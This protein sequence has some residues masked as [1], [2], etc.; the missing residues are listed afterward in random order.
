MRHASRVAHA[1]LGAIV[2]VGL[3]AAIWARSGTALALEPRFKAGQA[4]LDVV[5][6]SGASQ[7]YDLTLSGGYWA[8]E[9]EG[10]QP[11]MSLTWATPDGAF[12]GGAVLFLS[13]PAETGTFN[14]SPTDALFIS[15]GVPGKPTTYSNGTADPEGGGC[16]VTLAGTG[17]NGS[18]LEG[19][20]GSF[21][22]TR[23]GFRDTQ[24]GQIDATGTFSA[25][26]AGPTA[27]ATAT[28]AS[29]AAFGVGLGCGVREDAALRLLACT[30]SPFG[31]AAD[32]VLSYAWRL[33]GVTRAETGSTMQ[34]DIVRENL[35]AGNHV[36]GVT[37]TDTRNNVQATNSASVDTTTTAFAV[38]VV[39]G[40]SESQGTYELNCSAT[41]ANPP[42]NADLSYTW[43]VNGASI[44]T[45]VETLVRSVGQG[46]V[47]VT[48][49]ARDAVS[50]QQTN[51]ASFFLTVN[52]AGMLTNLLT[53][54][55]TS[56]PQ[57]VI[58][59]LAGSAA[60]A[61]VV[62]ATAAIGGALAG[63]ASALGGA[64]SAPAGSG[65]QPVPAPGGA[66]TTK[67]GPVGGDVVESVELV[68]Q[69]LPEPPWGLSEPP[70]IEQ[71]P[72]QTPPP[73]PP[74]HPATRPS[75]Q[76]MGSET[77][78]GGA[79]GGP[80]PEVLEAQQLVQELLAPTEGATP[81]ATPPSS[82]VPPPAGA[83]EPTTG[84][85]PSKAPTTGTTSTGTTSEQVGEGAAELLAAEAGQLPAPTPENLELWRA[86][87]GF[88]NTPEG[89]AAL[90]R[91][92]NE[93]RGLQEKG[94]D[95]DTDLFM[96]MLREQAAEARSQLPPPPETPYT[97]NPDQPYKDAVD[98]IDQSPT[99]EQ[100]RENPPEKE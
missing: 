7:A 28:T 43:T 95:I 76:P 57:N 78:G 71:P 59:A 39:C 34:V 67:L 23:L 16:T 19:I 47:Q 81:S 97:P 75:A 18:A 17:P 49:S 44:G 89:T 32:A 85:Q 26:P 46:P 12:G 10:A 83:T 96:R 93:L 22:C 2:L 69:I 73:V 13:G 70:P 84:A 68:A 55:Q 60:V 64:G 37:V 90:Q 54:G 51:T 29:P 50:G 42:P 33:D 58:D 87:S 72:T 66:A 25:T 3:S 63:A 38:S 36:I 20:T 79:P 21:R 77:P 65:A 86:L 1:A 100:L 27:S 91:H 11:G 88:P 9:A 94:K 52:P 80:T 31:Q 74:P 4:H 35:A 48:V 53:L 98:L 62:G 14:P 15:I 56:D 8:Q 6:N 41:A 92:L 5:D 82:R 45:T 30:A 40:Y 61:L 24:Y 99:A